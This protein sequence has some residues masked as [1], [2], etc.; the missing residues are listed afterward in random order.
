MELFGLSCVM[1]SDH[2]PRVEPEVM[3]LSEGSR[4]SVRNKSFIRETIQI[5]L[6]IAYHTL[7]LHP[8]AI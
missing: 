3:I 4:L 7:L 1:H 6:R 8:V 2:V 5:D